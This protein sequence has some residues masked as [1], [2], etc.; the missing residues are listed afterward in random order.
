MK[1]FKIFLLCI[2][3]SAAFSTSACSIPDLQR[4][5]KFDPDSANL[6]MKD[7]SALVDWF[8]YWRDSEGIEYALVFAKSIQ[9]EEGFTPL[10]RLRMKN[11]SLLLEP[12]LKDNATIEYSGMQYPPMP[13]KAKNALLNEIDISIQ[14]QCK[15]SGNCCGGTMK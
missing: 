11:I 12:L 14:P 6:G 7:A 10:S 4:S 15:K 5:V 3:S 1:S 8:I 13:K 9:D 2:L